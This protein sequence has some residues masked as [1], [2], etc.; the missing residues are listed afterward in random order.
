MQNISFWLELRISTKKENK[1]KIRTKS[2]RLEN[3]KLV[4]S[5]GERSH[6][7]VA[8][9]L[10]LHPV[11]PPVPHLQVGKLQVQRGQLYDESWGRW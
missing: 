3:L 8:G 1:S 7:G 6:D 11:Q 10:S 4:V 5:N 9:L 2:L